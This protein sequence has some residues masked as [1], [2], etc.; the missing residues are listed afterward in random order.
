MIG[1]AFIGVTGWIA[2]SVVAA[3]AQ[4]PYVKNLES[5]TVS[6]TVEAIDK[7]DRVVTLKTSDGRSVTMDVGESVK[8]FD[9]LK[10]G[11][12]VKGTYYE[13]VVLVIEQPG[14]PPVTFDDNL[15][16][17]PGPGNKPGGTLARQ[18]KAA[19]TIEEVQRDTGSVT[20]RGDRGRVMSFRVRDDKLLGRLKKGDRIDVTYTAALLINVEP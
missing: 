7:T 3:G 8:R 18:V 6:A 19:G 12:K 1:K 13:N 14:M 17:T 11:D 16:L 15:A 2:L 20:V 9:A 5:M 4:Q 10:V